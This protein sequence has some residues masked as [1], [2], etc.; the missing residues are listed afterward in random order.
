MDVQVS[1][2]SELFRWEENNSGIKLLDETGLRHFIGIDA[3]HWLDSY[4]QSDVT[5]RIYSGQVEYNGQTQSGTQTESTDTDYDGIQLEA[6]FRYYPKPQHSEGGGQ[7]GIR[8]A[9]GVDS[10]RRNIHDSQTADGT[11]ISGYIEN[12]AI[13]YGRMGVHYG[14][15]SPLSFN[16]GV[17]YPFYTNETIELKTLGYESD[18]TLHPKGRL[19]LHADVGLQFSRAWG[20]QLYFDSYRFAKS[21][22][23]PVYYP[24]ANTTYLVWQPESRQEVFGARISFTF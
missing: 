2:G 1:A 16:L 7:S 23:E 21:D 15:G 19:S 12:Y 18:V 3:N 17:K 9:L 6:G 20:G 10:W 4:W 22:A 14:G 8:L 11:I 13:A 5:G 24:T